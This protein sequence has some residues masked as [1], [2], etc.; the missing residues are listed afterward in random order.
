MHTYIHS[1]DDTADFFTLPPSQE[2]IFSMDLH[3]LSFSLKMSVMVK[4]TFRKGGDGR[5]EVDTVPEFAFVLI[6]S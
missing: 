3:D 1:F 6:I 4:E 2:P 5:L